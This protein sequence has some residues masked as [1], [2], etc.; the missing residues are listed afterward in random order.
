MFSTN[1]LATYLAYEY[2]EPEAWTYVVDE[3]VDGITNLAHTIYEQD[4]KLTKM[5]A[6]NAFAREEVI[7]IG[8]IERRFGE[9][10]QQ[11]DS[12]ISRYQRHIATLEAE[13]LTQ[14]GVIDELE[15]SQG[16]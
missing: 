3:L 14:Q 9:Q 13:L 2:N 4:A 6:Q 5:V 11:R 12:D 7:R 1:D 16:D 10:I 15:E 8:G